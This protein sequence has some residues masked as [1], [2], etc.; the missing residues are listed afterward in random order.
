MWKVCGGSGG[1]GAEGD[2]GW[3]R[4]C[5]RRQHTVSC[6]LAF[7][8]PWLPGCVSGHLKVSFSL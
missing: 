5:A 1:S 3:R 4:V 6:G 2:W 8:V 7:P